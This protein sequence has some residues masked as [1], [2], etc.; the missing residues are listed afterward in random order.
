MREMRR[1]FLAY[2]NE[3]KGREVVATLPKALFKSWFFA[4][5]NEENLSG[6][7]VAPI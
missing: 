7:G 5:E 4:V 2:S 3:A 1:F 6:S